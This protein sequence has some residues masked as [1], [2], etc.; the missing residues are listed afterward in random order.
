MDV[1]DGANAL[2]HG[3]TIFH[4]VIVVGGGWA[5]MALALS[6]EQANIDYIL[7]EKGDFA[8]QVGASVV[9]S[10]CGMRILDQLNLMQPVLDIAGT[11]AYARYKYENGAI[12][13]Q[14]D[15]P[16][17]IHEYTGYPMTV[18]SRKDLLQVL[19]DGIKDKSKCLAHTSVVSFHE[20][21]EGVEV[22]CEDGTTYTGSILIGADGVHS[23]VRDFMFENLENTP[24]KETVMKTRSALS[25]QFSCVFGL[26][27]PIEA[28]GEGQIY[29]IGGN[30]RS[31]MVVTGK[32]AK[33]FFSSMKLY[34]QLMPRI[35][36]DTLRK[37][38]RNP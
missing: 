34:P 33:I 16:K 15:I 20:D 5:G 32:D 35:F 2:Q 21:N 29:N 9:V 12:Y 14:G 18:L 19:Y 3:Q 36:L 23:K 31:M 17:K 10:G 8:P 22:K 24:L 27:D 11:L 37:R 13:L 7:L 30:G 25:S 1:V 6:L 26:G 4:Q 28:L 38:Q